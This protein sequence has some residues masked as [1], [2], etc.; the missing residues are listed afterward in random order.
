[1]KPQ[2]IKSI[3]LVAV[4]TI[5]ASCASK[6]AE[7][8]AST[9]KQVPEPAVAI[10]AKPVFLQKKDFNKAKNA[11]NVSVDW[12]FH[13]YPSVLYKILGTTRE[14]GVFVTQIKVQKVRLELSLPITITQPV[15]FDMNE[16]EHQQALLTICS[17]VYKKGEKV[18]QKAAESTIDQVFVG[19]ASTEDGALSDAINNA[20]LAIGKIYQAETVDQVNFVVKEYESLIAKGTKPQPAIKKAFELYEESKKTAKISILIG[21]HPSPERL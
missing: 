13:C 4:S 7:K 19:R 18:A 5:L 17:E 2:L 3:L 10:T 9:E 15:K 16:I 6:T 12:K 21:P 8:P 14:N 1:M 11:K 20:S